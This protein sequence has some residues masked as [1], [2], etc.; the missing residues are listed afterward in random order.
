MDDMEYERVE[1]EHFAFLLFVRCPKECLGSGVELYMVAAF[2]GNSGG[3][4]ITG[5]F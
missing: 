2:S 4:T 5:H 1:Y 3:L